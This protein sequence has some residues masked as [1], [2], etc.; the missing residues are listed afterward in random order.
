MEESEV[1][2]EERGDVVTVGRGA[3]LWCAAELCRYNLSNFYQVCNIWMLLVVVVV[4][5]NFFSPAN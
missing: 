1:E 2:D 3:M 4:V 5:V